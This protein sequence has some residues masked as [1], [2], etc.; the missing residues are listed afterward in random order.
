MKGQNKR[1]GAGISG[2]SRGVCLRV[3]CTHNNKVRCQLC[4]TT[5]TFEMLCDVYCVGRETNTNTYIESYRWI[6]I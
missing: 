5:H 2:Y 1:G 4:Q 3:Y 6:D